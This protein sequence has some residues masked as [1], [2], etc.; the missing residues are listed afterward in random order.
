MK[1]TKFKPIMHRVNLNPEQ[2]VLSCS[3]Y[4]MG[5]RLDPFS[6]P[7]P[8]DGTYFE[9]VPSDGSWICNG[10]ISGYF[11]NYQRR[12]LTTNNWVDSGSI[13]S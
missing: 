11:K 6:Y 8:I 4:H 13:S 10:K 7:E 1:K 9:F 5:S 2:A 12:G 3:C